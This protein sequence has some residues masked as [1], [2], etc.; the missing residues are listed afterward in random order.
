MYLVSHTDQQ[1]SG[2]D[3]TQPLGINAACRKYFLLATKPEPEW[4]KKSAYSFYF[5]WSLVKLVAFD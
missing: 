2:S 4:F 3:L 5:S 1:I